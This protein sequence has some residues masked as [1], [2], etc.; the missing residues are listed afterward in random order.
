[1]EDAMIMSKVRKYGQLRVDDMFIDY[2][3]PFSRVEM[4][5]ERKFKTGWLRFGRHYFILRAEGQQYA[6]GN[7]PEHWGKKL[8]KIGKHTVLHRKI[9]TYFDD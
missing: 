9:K 7:V 1:M 3:T 2:G 6:D 5:F 4:F 8:F